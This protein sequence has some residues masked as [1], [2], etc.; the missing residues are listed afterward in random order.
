MASDRLR[1][2]RI[3]LTCC[4]KE[5]ESAELTIDGQKHPLSRQ[6][7]SGVLC[8]DFDPALQ[9]ASQRPFF[10]LVKCPKQGRFSRRKSHKVEFTS[11]EVLLESRNNGCRK[12][13]NDLEVVLKLF[14][15]S[16]ETTSS[17]GISEPLPSTIEGILQQC[18]RFRILVIGK[19]GVGKSSLIN[20]TFGINAHAEHDKRG[21]ADIK[22]ELTSQQNSRFILHDS[23]GFEQ[24]EEDTL[25]VV[26][27]FIKD[28]RNNEDIK[29]QLHAV[30]LCFQIPNAEAGQ[31]MME[32]GMEEFLQ[33]KEEILGDV[34]TIFIFTKYDVL[35][36][37]VE[38]AL[39]DRVEDYTEADVES[40]AK[41]LVEA[42][43]VEPI[44]KLTKDTSIP[45]IAVSTAHRE[46]LGGLIQLT[47]EKVSEYFGNQPGAGTSAVPTLA[48]I[49]QRV[50]PDLKIEGSITV[51]KERYWQAI[52]TGAVFTGRPMQD[53]LRVIHDDIIKLWNFRD[54]DKLLLSTEFRDLMVN[55]V[56]L[57]DQPVDRVPPQRSDTLSFMQTEGIGLVA[58]LPVILP[59]FVG[60]KLVEWAYQAYNRTPEVQRNFVV[61]IADLTN[62]LDILF[63]LT[64]CRNEQNLNIR[65]VKAAWKAYYESI[66]SKHVHAQ[67]RGCSVT[68]FGNNAV[69]LEI[70]NLVR[71]RYVIDQVLM[72]RVREVSARDLE[73]E[74]PW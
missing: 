21:W 16:S 7:D 45:Y 15:E 8:A 6:S 69:I 33:K 20:R 9:S 63:T 53:C 50:A 49:A 52:F 67:I 44:K 14:T 56:N 71:Q 27:Q 66:R 51:G 19:S 37:A 17:P 48:V 74:E 1:I 3:E 38:N 4:G 34:P 2:F 13:C 26:T 72:K 57:L 47:Y 58:F 59:L 68:I 39:S 36:T 35:A 25:G 43:C 54:E 55:L 40:G 11:N 18:P 62:V 60:L 42:Q 65:T 10:L 12:T 5:V 24:G 31:R 64:S 22:K 28:R 46:K 23:K 41:Q 70:E 30:W 29:E 73:R 32:T 61:Y